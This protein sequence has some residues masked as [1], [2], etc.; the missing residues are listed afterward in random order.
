LDCS[1]VSH[2]IAAIAK[3]DPGGNRLAPY[4]KTAIFIGSSIKSQIIPGQ[5]HIVIGWKRIVKE[6][7]ALFF[8]IGAI[9]EASR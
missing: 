5:K 8:F 7:P 2:E 9:L 6:M 4:A 1:A 3:L